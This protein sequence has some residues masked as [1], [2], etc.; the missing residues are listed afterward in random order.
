M[1]T[2]FRRKSNYDDPVEF[3]APP[4]YLSATP[5]ETWQKQLQTVIA[6]TLVVCHR[7]SSPRLDS[8][9]KYPDNGLLSDGGSNV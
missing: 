3:L 9:S 6:V 2:R 7:C 8:S 4:T 5:A 1:S